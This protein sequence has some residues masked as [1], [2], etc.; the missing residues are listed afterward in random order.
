[1][2]K[3]VMLLNCLVEALRKWPPTIGTDRVCTIPFTIQPTKPDEKPVYL[4]PG[5]II[6]LPSNGIHYD[7]KYWPNP[8]KFDPERFSDENKHAIQPYTYFPFGLGPRNCIGSRFALLEIKTI[9]F[10]I[11]KNFEIVVTEKTQIPLT[12]SKKSVN[13]AGENGIWLGLKPRKV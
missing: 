13:L 11:L 10:H 1:M 6:W 2:L 9:Y 7:P 8:H 5:D 3:K 12:I 4:K